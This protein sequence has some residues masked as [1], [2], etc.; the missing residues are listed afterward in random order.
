MNICLLIVHFLF[1]F[2]LSGLGFCIPGCSTSSFVE[3]L[4]L[5]L[6]PSLSFLRAAGSPSRATSGP[7]SQGLSEWGGVPFS[8]LSLG[9]PTC[10]GGG[11][12]LSLYSYAHGYRWA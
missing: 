4:S 10:Q 8:G 11:G 3:G 9:S 1:L 7:S 6:S 5:S 2:S 12:S